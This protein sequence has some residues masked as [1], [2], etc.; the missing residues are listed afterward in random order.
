MDMALKLADVAG[1]DKRK[2]ELKKRGKLRGLGMSNTIERAAAAS[3]EGA[4]IRFD[5]G[6][7][8]SIFSG[9]I[10]QG[11][12][13][14]TTFKQVVADKLGVHPNDIEYIQGD[15]DKVFFGE[16]TGGS[17]SATMSGAAFHNAGEK[18]ITKAKAIAAHNMKVD[19]ADVNFNEGIFSSTKSNQTMTIKDVA[20]AAFNPAKIPNDM[21]A[22]LYATAVY[23]ADVE[24]FP[25]GV[26]VCEIEVDPDTG[27][28]EIVRYNVVDDVGTVM[29][30]LLLKGQIVGGVAMGV[31]QILKEDIHFDSEGQ[32]TTGSFMDYAMPR[33][34]DF[35]M[36]EVKANPVPTKTNP[37]GVKGAGEAGCVGAMPA[38]ANAL[39]DALAEFGVKHIAMPATPEVVWRAIGNGKG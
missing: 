14:E 33:A 12:G 39:V 36:I 23:K 15:T 38:V 19:A 25:N 6:G 35:P 3:F 37:L 8:V 13:H 30:P 16:G 34:H 27:K 21:E 31:G 7:T 32:L 29:N 22:G 26:H 4:E 18:V 11:Q 20:L 5:R 10:N 9:S 24:N 1:F 17:R 28:S 2:A